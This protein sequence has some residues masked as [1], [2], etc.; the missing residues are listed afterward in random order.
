MERGEPAQIIL[1]TN[2]APEDVSKRPKL[3]PHA[4]TASSTA[5]STTSQYEGDAPAGRVRVES[6]ASNGHWHTGEHNSPQFPHIPKLNLSLGSAGGQTSPK[7]SPPATSL[8]GYR[9]SMFG[10]QQTLAWR[11]GQREELP[12]ITSV[13]DR[14]YSDSHNSNGPLQLSNRNGQSNPPPL[15]TS[16]STNSTTSSNYFTPR[17]PMEPPLERALP[18]PSMYGQKSTGNFENQLPPLRQPS[19]SPQSLN[20]QH[21]PN[22]KWRSKLHP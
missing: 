12:R 19:M 10:S 14:R 16:E 4:S 11:E 15:L 22:G 20:A 5:S 8:P 1:L 2:L 6:N 21:S 13:N 18:I 9:E 17:T 3:E 7:A